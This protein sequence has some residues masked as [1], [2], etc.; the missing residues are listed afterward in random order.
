[1][2]YFLSHLSIFSDLLAPRR[3]L[4]CALPLA[5]PL[6]LENE[7]CVLDDF[8]CSVCQGQL[9]ICSQDYCL[10]R[11]HQIDRFFS[12]YQYGGALAK[13]IP[14]WKYHHRSEFFPLIKVLIRLI[15]SRLKLSAADFDLVL[16]IPLFHSS[17]KKRNFNQALF[18]A[19]CGAAVLDVPLAKHQLVKN[20]NT[21]QQASLDRRARA[22]NLS[23]ETFKVREPGM[24]EGRKILLCDDVMTTGAT[25][26]TAATVLRR[27]GALSIS[28]LTL[29]RVES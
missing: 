21:P 1:M 17:L 10:N 14:L 19:S 4:L 28:T 12:G 8:L 5:H 16:A 29:A 22:F 23:E 2:A 26:K 6:V 27:A 18:I 15:L 13:I 24:V 9:V 25:L 20:F 11:S 7:K 3:C